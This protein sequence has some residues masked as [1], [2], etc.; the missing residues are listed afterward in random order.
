MYV[1]GAA[2]AISIGMFALYSIN[3]VELQSQSSGATNGILPFPIGD[4]DV[5][6]ALAHAG[7]WPL[8]G[9]C[10]IL[11]V[12]FGMSRFSDGTALMPMVFLPCVV[13]LLAGGYFMHYM[14]EYDGDIRTPAGA[15]SVRA[16]YSLIFF[17]MGTLAG[18]WVIKTWKGTIEAIT[19]IVTP[20]GIKLD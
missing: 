10:L 11:I 1:L 20:M 9:I 7:Y 5:S 13:T 15:K 2:S 19:G 3:Y 16:Y 18:P 8:I 4:A 17:A 12:N 14:I 6:K